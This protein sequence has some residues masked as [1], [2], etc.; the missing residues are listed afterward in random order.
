M[1]FNFSCIVNKIR[2]IRERDKEKLDFNLKKDWFILIMLFAFLFLIMVFF[3]RF[4]FISDYKTSLSEEAVLGNPQDIS[5]ENISE[6]KLKFLLS[7]WE[8]KKLK[9]EQLIKERPNFDFL[10]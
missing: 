1:K 2:G 3:Y 6:A 7:K 10:P 4:L 8:E 9:Y 5:L